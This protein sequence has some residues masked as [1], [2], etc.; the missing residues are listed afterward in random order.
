MDSVETGRFGARRGTRDD[1]IEASVGAAEDG[2]ERRND[3]T[4]R[5]VPDVQAP[6]RQR[7]VISAAT[8]AR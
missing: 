3:A 5:H 6:H 8:R 4:L 7:V 1:V 2:L